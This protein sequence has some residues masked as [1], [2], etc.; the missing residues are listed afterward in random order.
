I[1]PTLLSRDNWDTIAE[2]SRWS[3]AN[4]DTLVDTHWVGGDPLRLEPYGWA[5]WS[6]RKGILTLR[7]PSNVPQK[8][9][10]DVERAF[11]LPASAPRRYLATSPWVVDRG[12]AGVQFR[13]GE[14][15]EIHLAPFEV[16]TLEARM[17]GR[18]SF[19]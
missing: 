14:E 8:I 4:A 3:R 1:T 17:A 7:N 15:R 18:G 16:L 13:A 19:D 10:I 11:E 2:C 9:A 12:R 6:P 5:S